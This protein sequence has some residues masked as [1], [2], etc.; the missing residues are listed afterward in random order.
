M[1]TPRPTARLRFWQFED[2]ITP[3]VSVAMNSGALVLAG[4]NTNND[5]VITVN[6][7]NTLDVQ[8]NGAPAGSFNPTAGLFATMGTGNDKVRL[9]L[10]G[11]TATLTNVV[12]RGGDGLDELSIES[13]TLQASV[14][15]F[16]GNGN[17]KLT[18]GGATITGAALVLDGGAGDD[19]A[20]LGGSTITAN[21]WVSRAQNVSLGGANITGNLV[22]LPGEA[23]T[24]TAGSSGSEI[25][26]N[27]YYVG[28]SADDHLNLSGGTIV[29]GSVYARLGNGS[30]SVDILPGAELNRVQIWGGTGND[31]VSIA[32]ETKNIDMVL[33][34]G[35]NSVTFG[36]ATVTGN[37]RIWGGNGADSVAMNAHGS[38]T[39]NISLYMGNGANSFDGAQNVGGTFNYVG[40]SGVDTVSLT[41]PRT[42]SYAVRLHLGAGDD[43]FTYTHVTGNQDVSSF[44]LNFGA[45]TDT[46]TH[47]VPITWP[48]IVIGLP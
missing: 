9:N 7:G 16:G 31:T 47:N 4:D 34:N 13:G 45:G 17:D 40:G 11:N 38:V 28:T 8:V 3:A 10:N 42:T 33:G 46:F 12:I 5:V 25:S 2:R 44:Y 6:A 18:I 35:T 22:I 27:F 1:T 39:G 36:G 21:T 24:T 19:N 14:W 43:A 23:K 29:G 48:S 41:S 26:G 20:L 15:L 32:A 37:L 30:N